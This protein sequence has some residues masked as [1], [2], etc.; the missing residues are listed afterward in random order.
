MCINKIAF[1]YHRA[2]AVLSLYQLVELHGI[3][4]SS[5]PSLFPTEPIPR[6]F[7]IIILQLIISSLIDII[8]TCKFLV[9]FKLMLDRLL[10]DYYIKSVYSKEVRRNLQY[11]CLF[12]Y[13]PSV[14][15]SCFLICLCVIRI[16]N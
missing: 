7:T 2:S 8:C 5:A 4:Y 3:S 9:L 15:F 13:V 12:L 10:N 11:R 16:L 14:I 6:R 1:L